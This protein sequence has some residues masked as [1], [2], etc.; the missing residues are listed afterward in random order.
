MSLSG[1]GL[2]YVPCIVTFAQ[3]L[4]IME[5]WTAEEARF[6]FQCKLFTETLVGTEDPEIIRL[7]FI[8]NVYHI[9]TGTY[10]CNKA[11]AIQLASLQVQAKF[12]KHNPATHKVGF[13]TSSLHEY[14][15]AP[16]MAEDDMDTA[17]WEEQIFQKHAISM[18]ESPMESYLAVVSRR[19]YYG[20]VLFGVKQRYDK[21]MPKKLF[22]GVA[23]QGILL[24]RI[25]NTFT[26]SDGMETLAQ[27]PLADIYRWAY[28]PGVNFYFEL[29][30][31]DADENPV[32]TFETQEGQHMSD[33]LTDYALALLREMGLNADGSKREKKVAAKLKDSAAFSNE[34]AYDSVDG[35][36][37]ALAKSAARAAQWEAEDAEADEVDD[38]GAAAAAGGDGEEDVPAP[39]SKEWDP[40]HET[41]YYFNNDTGESSWE[42]P[43]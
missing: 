35:D 3:V 17:A 42:V 1:N 28:K 22:L 19:D 24:L 34:S 2:V 33:L 4:P 27:Y 6:V 13:L 7:L 40:N 32:F 43:T 26:D 8:Q 12:G 16:F 9:I 14:V 29:K 23:R 20:S 5:A 36:A 25:P 30:L 10:P 11:D 41:Y 37:G 39:W 15:P 18:T 31:E 21:E 38:D